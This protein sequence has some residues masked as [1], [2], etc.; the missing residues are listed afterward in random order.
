MVF[1]GSNT[2]ATVIIIIAYPSF[3]GATLSSISFFF[4]FFPRLFF[5]FFFLGSALSSEA[6]PSISFAS[7]RAVLDTV[8]P[9]KIALASNLLNVALDPLLESAR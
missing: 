6:D 3:F 5:F 2:I 1:L 8:T 9:L 4:F 7:F